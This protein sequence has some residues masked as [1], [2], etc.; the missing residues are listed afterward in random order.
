MTKLK[1]LFLTLFVAI[2][3]VFG[4]AF[5]YKKYYAPHEVIKAKIG[6]VVETVYGLGTVSADRIFR[7]R[8]SIPLTV[9][10]IFFNEGSFVKT[11]DPLIQ[12]DDVI[13]KSQIDGTIT[14]VTYKIGELVTPQV[15]LVTVTNLDNLYL[16]VSLEQQAVLRVKKNQEVAISFENL[17]DEK[18]QGVVRS[19]YPRESQFI[20]RI[21]LL[22]WPVGVMPGMT[23]DVGI[24][25]GKKSNVILIPIRSLLSGKVIK[26]KNG[27]K[28][29][30]PV[31]LGTVDGEWGEVLSNNINVD[32]ELILRK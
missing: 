31:Q 27:K 30:V 6:D 26:F 25:V 3:F 32:D 16:E 7:V 22:K 18:F 24:L 13:M 2:F 9:R 15:A 14:S 21:E 28:E 4:G 23:A 11:G 1:K 5:L 29:T 12:L 20:V 10:K 17:R 8:T 19:V